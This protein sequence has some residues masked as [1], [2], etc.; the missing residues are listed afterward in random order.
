MC[1]EKNDIEKI[2]GV[3]KYRIKGKLRDEENGIIEVYGFDLHI[4]EGK[5]P[6]DIE[7]ETYVQFIV[8]RIDIW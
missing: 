1:N 3:F 2:E 5:I 4:D 8:S 7:N 6:G